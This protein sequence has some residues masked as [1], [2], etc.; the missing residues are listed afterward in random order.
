MVITE[1][2]ENYLETI[3]VLTQKKSGVHAIDIC[4]ELGYS[5]PTVSETLKTLRLGGFVEVD[6][7]HH[8]TLTHSG[9]AIAVSVRERHDVLA[10]MLIAIGVSEETALTEAC[11]IE[12]D[13]SDETIK[14]IKNYFNID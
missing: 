3:L 11:K 7:D 1:A 14:C 5:R 8:V 13:I 12:H 6:D 10:K 2:L 9:R 4:A